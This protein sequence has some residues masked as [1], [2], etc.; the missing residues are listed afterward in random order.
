MQ[1]SDAVAIIQMIRPIGTRILA[2]ASFEFHQRSIR[3]KKVSK[4]PQ[5]CGSELR[6]VSFHVTKPSD[7]RRRSEGGGTTYESCMEGAMQRYV[8][9]KR[10]HQWVV[11]ANGIDQLSCKQKRTAVQ[12]AKQANHQ[13]LSE[14]TDESDAE[15]PQSDMH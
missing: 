8:I 13:F 3:H 1:A 14:N 15:D 12:I 9:G 11:S 10:D 6:I 4:S 5:V 7:A 2:D